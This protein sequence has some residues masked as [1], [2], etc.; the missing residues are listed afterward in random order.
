ME[1]Y[2]T[3]TE[4]SVK[5]F[6]SEMGGKNPTIV[7]ESADI[8]KS[9]DGV[10]RAAYGYGGQKCSACSR[11]YV[12]KNIADKFL[13]KLVEKTNSLQIGLP[14]KKNTFLG[15]LINESAQKKFKDAIELA[16]KDGEIIQGGNVLENSDYKNGYYVEPTIITKLPRNHRLMK[17]ELFVPILCVDQFDN[18]DEAI[19]LANETEYGLTAGIFTENKKELE[20]FF[21]KI[22]AGTVYANRA[23]S[24]TTSALVRSQPFVGWKNSGSSGKGAGGVNYLQQFMRS[25]TQTRCA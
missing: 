2:Q 9:T 4:K 19:K 24:A 21:D 6:I 14:W 11:V 5:P 3:F 13:K 10:L 12:H 1:G 25:Q 17:E 18:F 8:E 20:E 7:T 15:P 23:A 22:Q 16:K